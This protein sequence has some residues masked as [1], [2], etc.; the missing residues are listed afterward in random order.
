EVGRNEGDH[1]GSPPP[2][3]R[4]SKM[5]ASTWG[6]KVHGGDGGCAA[7]VRVCKEVELQVADVAGQNFNFCEAAV[8]VLQLLPEHGFLLRAWALLV[9]RQFVRAVVDVQMLVVA[10]F[11]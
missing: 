9:G 11:L 7:K 2:F 1:L 3:S 8:G 10:D 4:R 5:M 6:E